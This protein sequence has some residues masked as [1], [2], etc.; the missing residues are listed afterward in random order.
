MYIGKK[1]ESG[2]ID[3]AAFDPAHAA[4]VANEHLQSISEPRRRQILINFRDHALAEAVGDHAA[5]MATCSQ[6]SQRYEAYGADPD[7][8]ALQPTD[9]AS[10][11][12]YYKMLIDTNM[13]L[14]HSEVEKLIVGT[15]C[16]LAELMVHQIFSGEQAID[17][18]GIQ[19]ADRSTVYQGH[20]RT[21]VIFTFDEKGLGNGEQAYAGDGAICMARM[22]ALS[23][24]EVPA[25][26]YSGP[27]TVADYLSDHPGLEWP[28]H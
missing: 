15:D 24:N 26:F 10:L 6:E 14:I 16:L 8:Q 13:Y 1:I 25:Q 17:F 27:G 21:A 18:F 2:P 22:T 20:T 5:L 12:D 7:F 28:D 19:E 23:D 3:M 4:R 11:F 9:Y